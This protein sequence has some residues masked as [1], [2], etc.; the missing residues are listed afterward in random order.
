MRQRRAGDRGQG[1]V[2]SMKRLLV[3]LL[4][5]MTASA[6]QVHVTTANNASCDVGT[7]AAAT[8]LLPYFE[9]DCQQPT[10]KAMNTVFTVINTS[11]IPQL[12]RVTVWTDL[13]Y[14][15]MWFPMFLTGYDVET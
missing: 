12:V 3:I 2:E 13:G 9:V 4:F 10:S 5:S 6:A 1:G 8:L 7:Y 14:P 15:V 11:R